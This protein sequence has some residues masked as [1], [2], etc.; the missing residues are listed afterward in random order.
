LFAGS[1]GLAGWNEYRSVATEKT[2]EA[3]RSNVH[4]ILCSPVDPASQGLL[5]HAACDLSNFKVFK[6]FPGLSRLSDSEVTG[7]RLQQNA[8][9]SLCPLSSMD[10]GS[11][12]SIAVQVFEWHETV[13]SKTTKDPVCYAVMNQRR[14]MSH[15]EPP[16]ITYEALPLSSTRAH[17]SDP[18]RHTSR[19]KNARRPSSPHHADWILTVGWQTDAHS[20][21]IQLSPG[22][23]GGDR[24]G[25][26]SASCEWPDAQHERWSERIRPAGKGPGLGRA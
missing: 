7:I 1:L 13:M 19:R 26:G 20:G 21:L 22:L 14:A 25:L 5:V 15:T 2:I 8:E 9:V 4:D 17:V 12:T 11:V 23:V 10:P 24:P 18:T 6:G 16:R 3:A